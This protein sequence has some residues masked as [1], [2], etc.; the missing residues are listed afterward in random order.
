MFS[1]VN[2][3]LYFPSIR[4]FTRFTSVQ[5]LTFFFLVLL[6]F[7]RL[8]TIRRKINA[9]DLVGGKLVERGRKKQVA[10]KSIRNSLSARVK[11]ITTM[12]MTLERCFNEEYRLT[13][14]DSIR[15]CTR[16]LFRWFISWYF[17]PFVTVFYKKCTAL[18][19]PS[20][21][22]PFFACIRCSIDFEQQFRMCKNVERRGGNGSFARLFY[23]RNMIV[24]FFSSEQF[25]FAKMVHV[26][27]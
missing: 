4:N 1:C 16:S 13:S 12:D 22:F 5:I 18:K 23:F 26:H 2:V 27:F 14:I 10:I 17:E 15:L 6:C 11:I 9:F 20:V 19:I 21:P 3:I 8:K 25:L 24:T 7:E